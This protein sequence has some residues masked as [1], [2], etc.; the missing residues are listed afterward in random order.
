MQVEAH[1][2]IILLQ[3]S[4]CD[5]SRYQFSPINFPNM[6]EIEIHWVQLQ[7]LTNL[8]LLLVLLCNNICLSYVLWCHMRYLKQSILIFADSA[9]ATGNALKD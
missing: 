8:K 5:L 1:F 7:V 4:A 6:V 9:K 3:H 2:F